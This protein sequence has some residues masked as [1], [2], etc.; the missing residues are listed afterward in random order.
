MEIARCGGPVQASQRAAALLEGGIEPAAWKA[1]G[2]VHM[3][4]DFF[5]LVEESVSEVTVE[6]AKLSAVHS[7]ST[8][9]DH[10][11]TAEVLASSGF[12]R[13][14]ALEHPGAWR[15]SARHGG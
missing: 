15:G 11:H 14:Q 3:E 4:R 6:L 5:G 2:H 13:G 8:V 9:M 7:P 10:P 1:L 12:R